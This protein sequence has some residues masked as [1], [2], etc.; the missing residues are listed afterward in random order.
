MSRHLILIVFAFFFVGTGRAQTGSPN[1]T[2]EVRDVTVK[3]FIAELEK[4][5]RFFFYFNSV[6]T[7]SIRINI[8]V[9]NEA[10]DRVL[11][12]AFANT[13]IRYTILPENGYVL[14]TK[15]TR[16]IADLPGDFF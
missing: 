16:I 9:Q 4:Q 12:K 3:S 11:D 2:L 14:L 5:T 1:I 10:L 13:E 6:D 15:G 7:D 8:I